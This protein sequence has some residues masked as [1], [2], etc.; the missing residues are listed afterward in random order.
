[1]RDSD[2]LSEHV[3][4]LK[5]LGKCNQERKDINKKIKETKKQLNILDEVLLK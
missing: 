3:R 5:F 2:W 1:M 4:L